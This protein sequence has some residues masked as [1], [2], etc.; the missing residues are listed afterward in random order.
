[1][2]EVTFCS[3]SQSAYSSRPNLH[4]VVDQDVLETARERVRTFLSHAME[5]PKQHIQFFNK[6]ADL[7]SRMVRPALGHWATCQLAAFFFSANAGGREG[8]RV[9][10][11]GALFSR[12][13]EDGA[14]V[15]KTDQGASIR[16][17]Q[18]ADVDPCHL[19]DSTTIIIW[20]TYVLC[21]IL[22]V[23]RLGLF[24]LQVDELNR[25]L[26]KRATE[27]CNQLLQRMCQDNQALNTESAPC[28]VLHA[29]PCMP[30]YHTMH[31]CHVTLPCMP[32][33]LKTP[34]SS[35]INLVKECLF[36][37]VSGWWDLSHLFPKIFQYAQARC[38]KYSSHPSFVPWQ[39]AQAPF[40]LAAGCHWLW[41]S[42]VC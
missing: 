27:L 31:A 7:V 20:A 4:P 33:S 30:H 36:G 11:R 13:R 42:P 38:W 32:R 23:V 15:R 8:K 37:W 1:M 24:E 19:I 12:V 22:Q 3:S 18:G 14:V 2:F 40:I 35:S 29:I 9:L 21:A 5:A 34:S 16:R 41:G 17:G 28:A 10:V 25:A 39:N 6:Y 26:A